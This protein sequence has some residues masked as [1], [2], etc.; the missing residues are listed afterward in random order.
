MAN[1]L[2]DHRDFVLVAKKYLPREVKRPITILFTKFMKLVPFSVK[3]KYGMKKRQNKLPYSMIQPGDTV[4]QIGAPWDLLY[5]GRSRAIYFSLFVGDSGKSLIVEPD[6]VSAGRVRKFCL[7]NKIKS[8]EIINSGAW[9][10][11]TEL[12]FLSKKGHPASN[13]MKDAV[14]DEDVRSYDEVRVPVNSVDNMVESLG[15]AGPKLVSITTNGSE[16]PILEGMASVISSSVQHIS[17]AKFG[18]RNSKEELET[19]ELAVYLR[20]QGFECV[21]VDDRGLFFSKNP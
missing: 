19:N 5:T 9:S 4:M 15:V 12:V 20:G 16:I 3:Y 2:V 13:L 17:V 14:N 18:L 8:A 11:K 7:D 10:E 1:T 6:E 21:A